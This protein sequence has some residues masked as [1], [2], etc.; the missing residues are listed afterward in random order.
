MM[1]VAMVSLALSKTEVAEVVNQ[2]QQEMVM[3][4]LAWS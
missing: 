4:L 1:H 3:E 2:R